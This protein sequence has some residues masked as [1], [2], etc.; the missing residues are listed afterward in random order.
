MAIDVPGVGEIVTLL[1][2]DAISLFA[3]QIN[4]PWGI[5]LGFLPIVQADTVTAFD[6]DQ[7]F[8]ISDYPVEQGQFQSYNKVYRPFETTFRFSKGGT[9]AQRQLLLDSVQAIIGDTNLYNVVTADATYVGVN[10]VGYSYSQRA[11]SGLGLI[12]VDVRA[13]QVKETNTLIS[14]IANFITNAIDPSNDSQVNGGTVQSSSP[15]SFQLSSL[16]SI[17]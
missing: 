4:A 16:A 6:Y 3:G 5:Y 13:R 7:D 10:L 8:D 11:D 14:S 12:Q 17:F 9:L 15:S 2:Q 1:T